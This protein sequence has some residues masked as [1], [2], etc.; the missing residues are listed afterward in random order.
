[1]LKLIVSLIWFTILA[2]PCFSF[3][4]LHFALETLISLKVFT[5]S[6]LSRPA[7]V[8]VYLTFPQVV[9]RESN[10]AGRRRLAH[11]LYMRGR[12]DFWFPKLVYLDAAR[13]GG[14]QSNTFLRYPTRRRL[15]K[16]TT[17]TMVTKKV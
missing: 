14:I 15:D 1:M 11:W 3:L 4:H 12:E 10:L 7:R 2:K 13:F 6:V 8:R 17:A 5:Q 9:S 16:K